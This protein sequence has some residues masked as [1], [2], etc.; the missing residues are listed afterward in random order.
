MQPAVHQSDEASFNIAGPIRPLV[1]RSN[2]WVPFIFCLALAT[3][4]G[5]QS[6]QKSAAPLPPPVSA[7]QQISQLNG[8]ARQLM[9]L[10]LVGSLKLDYLGRLGNKHE[11]QTHFVMMIDQHARQKG[12]GPVNLLLSGTYL[13]E[14]VF[15]MGI[16]HRIYWLVN[17]RDKIAYI[18]HPDRP[19]PAARVIPIDPRQIL[20]MLAVGEL[21]QTAAQSVVMTAFPHDRYNRLFVIRHQSD[22]GWF[23]QRE[24][25]VDRL[26]GNVA[27]VAMFAPDGISEARSGLSD[28]KAVDSGHG[29][30]PVMVPMHMDLIYPAGKAELHLVVSQAMLQLKVPPKY[31]FASPDFSGLRLVP[32]RSGTPSSIAP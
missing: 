21:R 9:T 5:C 11:F 6:V 1:L 22:G 26:T 15:E 28:Y 16:N 20:Q 18:G 29:N 13:G 32:V 19:D 17:R 7:A 2:A 12:I 30:L 27:Q 14:N 31:A 25:V 24:L 3:L 10:R 23:V 8:R 4:A